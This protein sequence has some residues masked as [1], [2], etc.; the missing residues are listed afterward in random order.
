[1]VEM[2]VTR[3][4]EFI[5]IIYA[6]SVL[7]YFI[8]FLQ[9]NRKVNA[10]A[11]WLLAFVW[12][13][14]TFFLLLRVIETGRFPILSMFEGLYFYA[15]VLITLSLVLN[16]LLRMDFIIFFTNV[17][18]FFIMALHTF[19]PGQHESSI[20]TGQLI[21]ELLMI[22]ITMAILSYG[23][24]SL[25]FVFSI[26]YVI[27]YDLLKKKKWGKR[28]LRI[29]D[30]SKLDH[31]SY[32][33]NV[34]GVPILLLSLILGVLWAFITL[35]EF[36]LYDVKV[37]GSFFVLLIFS[38]NLYKRVVHKV[39]GKTI[40]LWNIAA[41]LVLLINFFLFGSLSQFHFWS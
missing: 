10:I 36:R 38:W 3:L 26:L 25:S 31:M 23:A 11:F 40:A 7:F 1:M 12:V 33:L 20:L 17:I 19:A 27:Q 15:W 18:G 39:Q 21:S 24:F 8:D 14:Q 28:L 22:H 5:V 30:L 37:L 13:I 9:N 16:K 29:G 2:N 35:S 32:V 41:F 6:L 34:I 4:H